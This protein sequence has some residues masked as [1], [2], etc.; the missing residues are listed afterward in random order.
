MA[1]G[2]GLQKTW[3]GE[4]LP[5]LEEIFY[6][7]IDEEAGKA[8]LRL[9]RQEDRP[10]LIEAIRK[11]QG[12][13]PV[14]TYCSPS[15]ALTARGKYKNRIT[16]LYQGAAEKADALLQAL[17]ALQRKGDLFNED[18]AGF[19]SRF[20]LWDILSFIKSIERLDDLKG[21]LGENTDYRAIPALEKAMILNPFRLPPG[22]ETLLRAL[23]R[24]SDIKAP[25]NEFID[26]VFQNQCSEIKKRLRDG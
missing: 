20:N 4:V 11:S 23:P 17:K 1:Q 18:L 7:L 19:Q 10:D 8:F 5:I 16:A 2:R 6:Y 12:T 3:E 26:H 13:K 25:L 15:F 14:V 22:N 9:I 21:V 24:L